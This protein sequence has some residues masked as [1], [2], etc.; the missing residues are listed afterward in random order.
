MT[1]SSRGQRD[2]HPGRGFS[3]A[4]LGRRFSREGTGCRWWGEGCPWGRGSE[5]FQS[6]GG[7]AGDQGGVSQD[8]KQ[9][10]PAVLQ[11]GPAATRLSRPEPR[12]S[13]KA[14]CPQL[15]P[16]LRAPCPPPSA[17]L[18]DGSK[19]SR[20]LR[21]RAEQP[22]PPDP[23]RLHPA[24]RPGVERTGSPRTGFGDTMGVHSPSGTGDLGRMCR[25][26]HGLRLGS[27]GGTRS[28]GIVGGEGAAGQCLYL[29]PPPPPRAAERW[30]NVTNCVTMTALCPRW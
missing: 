2:A 9:V 22:R 20:G 24:A 26:V 30:T 29:Q 15:W 1:D 3:S 11:V 6:V 7:T 8:G 18:S 10:C 5:Q 28:L 27:C 19:G 14:F 21:S 16:H 13:R 12:A 17:G 4:P 25:Q 23:N